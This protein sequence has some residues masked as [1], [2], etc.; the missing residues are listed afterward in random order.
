MITQLIIFFYVLVVLTSQI[1]G[2][3]DKWTPFSGPK[4]AW[5]ASDFEDISDGYD[6]RIKQPN[7]SPSMQTFCNLT[8][9]CQVDSNLRNQICENRC[10]VYQKLKTRLDEPTLREWFKLSQF[11]LET[12]IKEWIESLERDDINIEQMMTQNPY[13]I[14]ESESEVRYQKA[15]AFF[16]LISLIMLFIIPLLGITFMLHVLV[17]PFRPEPSP[18]RRSPLPHVRSPPSPWKLSKMVYDYW[19]QKRTKCQEIAMVNL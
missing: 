13:V 11:E 9:P 10:L 8:D 18:D 14:K 16:T 19:F 3:L 12:K 7:L 4:H 6:S 15:M 2:Q 17:E 1:N 5:A